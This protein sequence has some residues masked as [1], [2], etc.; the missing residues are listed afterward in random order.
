MKLKI[1]G[2]S[3]CYHTPFAVLFG[4]SF[5]HS[6]QPVADF[7]TSSFEFDFLIYLN[8]SSKGRKPLIIIC[9]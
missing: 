6:K 4:L 5:R 1:V 2:Y 8:I 9:R 3:K 7:S